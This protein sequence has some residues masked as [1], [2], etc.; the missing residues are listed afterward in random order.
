MGANESPH[1]LASIESRTFRRRLCFRISHLR[2]IIVVQ[3]DGDLVHNRAEQ[4]RIRVEERHLL[5][6]AIPPQERYGD[7]V[8]SL[9]LSLSFSR[10][11]FSLPR[12]LLVSPFTNLLV[13][14]FA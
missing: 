13:C 10:S 2:A 7:G 1:C 14:L 5:R 11:L 3:P 12:A 8:L 4:F 9:S 6:Q